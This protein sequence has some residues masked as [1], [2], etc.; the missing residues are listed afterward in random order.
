MSQR[1][2]AW[3]PV[4]PQVQR[5]ACCDATPPLSPSPPSLR[6]PHCLSGALWTVAKKTVQDWERQGQ[7]MFTW[8]PGMQAARHE[9]SRTPAWLWLFHLFFHV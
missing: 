1:K 8:F 7:S 5:K 4:M 2:A 9:L 3:M 6:T